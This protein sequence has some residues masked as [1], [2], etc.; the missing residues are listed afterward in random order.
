[1]KVYVGDEGEGQRRGERES[2]VYFSSG[3][4]RNRGFSQRRLF[5]S[6]RLSAE[7]NTKEFG[8]GIGRIRHSLQRM[9]TE[10]ASERSYPSFLLLSRGRHELQ[11]EQYDNPSIPRPP[12]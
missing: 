9:S 4:N 5:I 8:P 6:A 12:L 3:K 7:K 10:R 1:M 2:A 11:Q